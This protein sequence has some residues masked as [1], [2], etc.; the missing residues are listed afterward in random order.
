MTTTEPRMGAFSAVMWDVEGDPILRSPITLV[1]ML[2]TVPDEAVI[3]DRLERLTRTNP[4]LRERAVGNPL[5]MVEPRWEVDPNFDMSYHI[6]WER[7]EKSGGG[8]AQVLEIAERITEADFDRSR[9]LWEMHVVTGL[10]GKQAAFIM[11]IHHSITDGE[12]GLMMAIGLF[13]LQRETNADLGPMPNAPTGEVLDEVGR[14]KQASKIEAKVIVSDFTGVAKGGVGLVKQAV[15]DPMASAVSAQEWAASAARLT[16]PASVPLS[17]LWTKRSLSLEF[18]VVEVALADLKAA[19]KAVG[20][21]LNDAFMAAV[22]GGLMAYHEAHGSHPDALRVNMPI[23][24]RGGGE[25]GAGGNK[26]VPA[27]FPMP[28][29]VKDPAARMRQLHP[30][31]LQARNEPALPLSAVVYRVLSTMPTPI[32]TRIAGGLM[33][34]TD[35]AATNVPGPPI[36]L[37][38]AGSKLLSMVPF[39]PKGGAAVNVALMSYDGKIFLGINIDRGAVEDPGELTDAIAT[40]LQEVL[41]VGRKSS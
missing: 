35:F 17:G 13:D 25:G 24:M 34:G 36:P 8:L 37:F 9:P 12:G 16:A 27:R 5:S 41:A 33:K 40:S 6:R 18:S 15:T 10:R 38:F 2:D 26:W 3:A 31:L 11:K 29:N 32:A 19:S 22:I 14:L 7:P 21:T 39:A 28:T 30:I 1:C 4:K 20:G 23:S